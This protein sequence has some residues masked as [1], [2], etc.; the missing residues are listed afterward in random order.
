M[1][2]GAPHGAGG[3][4]AAQA[5][6]W[7]LVA[8]CLREGPARQGHL[9]AGRTRLLRGPCYSAGGM[10]GGLRAVVCDF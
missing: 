6:G 8:C 9:V 1:T 5:A 3:W 10:C 4:Q 7:R 2:S